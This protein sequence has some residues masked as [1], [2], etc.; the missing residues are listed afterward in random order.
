MAGILNSFSKFFKANKASFSIDGNELLTFKRN[1]DIIEFLTGEECITNNRTTIKNIYEYD[2]I[3]K[4]YESISNDLRGK[5]HNL[6]KEMDNCKAA[7]NDEIF[8]FLVSIVNSLDTLEYCSYD[9]REINVEPTTCSYECYK[10]RFVSY[11][12]FL[13]KTTVDLSELAYHLLYLAF[14]KELSSDFEKGSRYSQY[15][16]QY[17][18]RVTL[19]YG[20]TAQIAY[21]EIMYLASEERG[22][23]RNP[24]AVFGLADMYFY[25]CPEIGLKQDLVKAWNL[26]CSCSGQNGD[27]SNPSFVIPIAVWNKACILLDYQKQGTHFENYDTIDEIENL[28]KSLRNKNLDLIDEAERLAKSGLKL[29][30]G[31]DYEEGL[32]YNLLG[33]IKKARYQ[34]VVPAGWVV[35]EKELISSEKFKQAKSELDEAIKFFKK[36]MECDFVYAYNNY[37]WC[38]VESIALQ[39]K[40]LQHGKISDDLRSF[41]P[42]ERA[43][44]KAIEYNDPYAA[45]LL[46]TMYLKGTYWPSRVNPIEVVGLKDEQKAKECFLK[47][48]NIVYKNEHTA[49]CLLYLISYF[50]NSSLDIKLA[51][52]DILTIERNLSF[53]NNFTVSKAVLS[54]LND[55]NSE[56]RKV[57]TEIDFAN[58]DSDC[59]KYI[60]EFAKE[61]G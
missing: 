58:N 4:K 47:G 33:R 43:L 30:K 56:L 12:E 20:P 18:E 8:D 49:W 24:I 53:G 5:L 6:F 59:Q 36:S 50:P 9:H 11:L 2:F 52:K 38:I 32:F 45:K 3:P 7:T 46:G 17:N 42:I 26:Y 16:A 51:I 54:T 34:N 28:R 41:K 10:E 61:I 14:F 55:K 1:K 60:D 22:S 25:G 48:A 23:Q 13:N 57:L 40:K 35:L 37:A 19:K 27:D 31:R 21:R 44:S 29:V 15:I 39:I